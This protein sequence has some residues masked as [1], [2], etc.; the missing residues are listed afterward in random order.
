MGDIC[1]NSFWTWR[2]SFRHEEARRSVA[3][4]PQGARG[5]RRRIA[6]PS[7]GLWHCRLRVRAGALY[8]KRSAPSH[9]PS[10]GRR[11][12]THGDRLVADRFL[13]C[14][15][16][17]RCATCIPQALKVDVAGAPSIFD[18][19]CNLPLHDDPKFETVAAP[20]SYTRATDAAVPVCGRHRGWR[21]DRLSL[22]GCHRRR[23]QFRAAT[24]GWR[25]GRQC[26]GRVGAAAAAIL[27]RRPDPSRGPGS[28]G[29][30][31][32][33]RAGGILP[34]GTEHTA[35][36]LAALEELAQR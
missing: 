10:A 3:R 13:A 4:E 21:G 31:A 20:R 18:Q 28:L 2:H 22:G 6:A 14:R 19:A 26:R 35:P 34:P 1:K 30:R 33:R 7:P 15:Y 23:G 29:G 11:N 5:R 24:Q 8:I 27:R 16:R 25:K 17:P 12:G 36:S 32:R 9:P